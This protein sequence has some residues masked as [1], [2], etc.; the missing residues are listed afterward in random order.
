MTEARAFGGERVATV[1]SSL[2]AGILG[3][4]YLK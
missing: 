1:E 2:A 3:G 4:V